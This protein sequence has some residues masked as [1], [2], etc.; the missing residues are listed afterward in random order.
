LQEVGIFINK[1][2]S[3]CNSTKKTDFLNLKVATLIFLEPLRPILRIGEVL[4][5]HIEKW[6]GGEGEMRRK[7]K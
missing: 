4:G 7:N 6:R 2:I 5:S 3:G 1:I